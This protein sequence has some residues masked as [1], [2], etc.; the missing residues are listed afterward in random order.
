VP[1]ATGATGAGIAGTTGATGSAGAAGTTGATG[2]TG[3]SAGA[4]VEGV[5]TGSIDVTQAV[6]TSDLTGPKV[7]A[8]IPASGRVLVVLTGELSTSNL[9]RTSSAFMSVSLD[10]S[11]ALDTNSLRV[12]GNNPVRASVT[13]LLTGLTPGNTVTFEAVYK[14]VGSG[15]ATF[16]ARQITV[17][18]N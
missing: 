3:P 9:F 5:A 7:Q 16:N 12:S 4:A 10:G 15:T 8:V 1:G 6:Y 14:L 2:A 11:V 13:L 17:I 18:P